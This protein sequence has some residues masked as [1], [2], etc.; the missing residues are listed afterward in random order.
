[1]KACIREKVWIG[2]FLL[3]LCG[4]QLCWLFAGREESA[5]QENRTKAPKPVF[6]F[7]SIEE[8]PAMY[9]AY[10]NDR[11]PWRDELI[12]LNSAL[13]YYVFQSSSNRNVVRGRDGW[14]F[15]NSDADDNPV[16]GYKGMQLF[17]EEELL[18]IADNLTVTQ[19][20]LAERGTEFVL[21]IAPNK[22]RIYAEKMPSYYGVPAEVYRTG[23][24][25]EYLRENTEIRVVYPY[26]EL[27]AARETYPWQ[28]YYRL[29]THWNYIGGYIGSCVLADEL[30]IPMPALDRLTVTE[31]EPTICDLADMLNLRD[32]L[33]TDR[34]YVI[35]GY[36]KYHLTTDRHDLTG[37]YVYHCE[38]GDDRKLFM[39][40][41]SFADAMDDFLASQFRSSCMVHYSSYSHQL[42]MQ[43]EPDIF[44]YETVERRVGELLD[45]RME[46]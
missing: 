46:L 11:L 5:G 13:E 32:A 26:E 42:A 4:S 38:G 18:R 45:F 8:Y 16:E 12:R 6:S 14:L 44:V 22:E 24:L 35:S 20:L 10:Y 2:M 7:A 31:T 29:D 28:L 33:N 25:V 41:D 39:L 27:L 19:A 43:E 15:Y 37:S 3:V 21:F 40:R 9:E 30:G 36:D 1:M 34:D 17:T 23:Q